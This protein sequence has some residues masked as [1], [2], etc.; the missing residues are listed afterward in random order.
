MKLRIMNFA[1]IIAVILS[2]C[3]LTSCGGDDNED[4]P[5]VPEE[6]AR[7]VLSNT[8]WKL[9][10]ITGGLI[11]GDVDDWVGE[12]FQFGANGTVTEIYVEGGSSNGT[13]T[14]D[15]DQLIL[16]NVALTD[17]FGSKY[18]YTLS[19]RTLKLLNGLGSTLTFTK[20]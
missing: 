6:T 3:A 9:Q 19:G 5:D 8:S 7:D 2:C 14:L 4:E 17:T 15:G 20:L 11:M 1:A 13:Y 18:T 16:D 10:S 12:I